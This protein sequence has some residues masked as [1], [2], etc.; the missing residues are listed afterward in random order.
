[1]TVELNILSE[2]SDFVSA[3]YRPYHA[4]QPLFASVYYRF[5]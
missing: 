1:M 5:K 3:T 2:V 4:T